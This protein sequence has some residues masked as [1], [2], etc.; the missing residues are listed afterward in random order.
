MRSSVI[1]SILSIR[2]NFTAVWPVHSSCKRRI[3]GSLY[4]W[5]GGFAS[6]GARGRAV[7]R[8]NGRP[9]LLLKGILEPY[10]LWHDMLAALVPT[11]VCLV[12][13]LLIVMR[14]RP[15]LTLRESLLV[16]ITLATGWLVLGIEL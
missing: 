8:S 5:N 15:A 9:P 13:T 3:T 14:T 2:L 4:R 1:C 12:A 10:D 11:L 6:V 7:V 16:S